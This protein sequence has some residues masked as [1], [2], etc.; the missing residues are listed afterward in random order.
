MTQRKIL[1]CGLPDYP[2]E[3]FLLGKASIS[4]ISG[5]FR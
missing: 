4:K 3:D 2:E 1:D 5:K